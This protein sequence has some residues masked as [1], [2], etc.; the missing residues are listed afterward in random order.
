MTAS[1]QPN[2]KKLDLKGMSVKASEFQLDTGEIVKSLADAEDNIAALTT[3][4]ITLSTANTYTDAAVKTAVDA[5]LATIVAKVDAIIAL[6]VT[7]ELI[8]AP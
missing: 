8:D 1:T 6:L 4:A 3:V 2:S 5:G 7:H